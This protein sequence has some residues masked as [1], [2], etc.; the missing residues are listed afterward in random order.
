MP[1]VEMRDFHV[2]PMLLEVLGHDPAVAVIVP[3]GVV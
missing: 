2:A 1:S 3:Q